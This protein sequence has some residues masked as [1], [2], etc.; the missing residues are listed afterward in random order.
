MTEASINSAATKAA[1]YLEELQTSLNK[2]SSARFLKMA[3]IENHD[4]Y[5]PISELMPI[6]DK[7]KDGKFDINSSQ[8]DLLRIMSIAARLAK[9]TG[10][11]KANS[12]HQS[13][14]KKIENSKIQLSIKDLHQQN[15]NS[16][17]TTIKITDNDIKNLA[18]AQLE[19]LSNIS[20][21]YDCF[22]E[23]FDNIFQMIMHF[24]TI[25]NSITKRAA[26][27]MKFT[28]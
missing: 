23:I 1:G 28:Q 7:Y 6:L 4:I 27:E 10:Y 20:Y 5:E 11:L 3:D 22:A 2:P 9:Y 16:G 12:K 8:E 17:K 19:E 14:T 21:E 25:L 13:N 24:S 15:I 26:E 18:E